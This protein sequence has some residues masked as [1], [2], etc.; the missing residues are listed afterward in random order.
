MSQFWL[1]FGHLHV[2]SHDPPVY[3]S[4]LQG[5]INV[6]PLPQWLFVS[7][8]NIVPSKMSQDS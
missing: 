5:I 2:T 8:V 4:G 1:S 3:S 7:L 6:D